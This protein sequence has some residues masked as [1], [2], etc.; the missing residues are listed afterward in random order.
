[1]LYYKLEIENE[2][3]FIKVYYKQNKL[4]EK[5]KLDFRI[6]EFIRFGK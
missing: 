2:E 3:F 5:E 4:T 6:Q 1:M